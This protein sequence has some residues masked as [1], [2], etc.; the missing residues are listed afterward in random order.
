MS[1]L[2][3]ELTSQQHKRVK[4]LAAVQGKSIKD[5]VLERVLSPLSANDSDADDVALRQLDALLASRIDEAE[6]GHV[7]NKSVKTIFDEVSNDIG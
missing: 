1:R 4:A 2:S 6:A 5:Y 7:V 3:I